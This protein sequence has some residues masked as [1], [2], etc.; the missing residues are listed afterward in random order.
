MKALLVGVLCLAVLAATATAEVQGIA[1][2][3]TELRLLVRP[4]DTVSVTGTAGGEV[5]G[6]VADLSASSLAL[7][8]NGQRRDLRSD[9]AGDLRAA[10]RPGGEIA[11]ITDPD[12]RT[13]GRARVGQVLMMRAPPNPVN[14]RQR[15][16]DRR[17][18]ALFVRQAGVETPRP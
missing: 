14:G 8:V 5:T 15:Q 6:K 7:V 16:R 3:F 17:R 13:Q 1:N 2:S 10:F 12:S 18:L 4:G 9:A 11:H